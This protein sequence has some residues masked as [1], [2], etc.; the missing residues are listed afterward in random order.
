MQL[1]NLRSLRSIE[2]HKRERSFPVFLV[3]AILIVWFGSFTFASFGFGQGLME[4]LST[5]Q[6]GSGERSKER[7]GE[8]SDASERRSPCVDVE[9]SDP[10]FSDV[11]GERSFVGCRLKSVA[12]GSFYDSLGM[13]VG[14]LVSPPRELPRSRSLRPER[15]RSSKARIPSTSIRSDEDEASDD[16]RTH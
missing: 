8:P 4:L 13:K 3:V 15:P 5:Q 12:K 16:D 7:T 14:E 2:L 10:V 9:N 1:F 6:K 11:D